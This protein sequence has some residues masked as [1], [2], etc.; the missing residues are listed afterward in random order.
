MNHKISRACSHL[1][2]HSSLLTLITTNIPVNHKIS[3]AVAKMFNS[4]LYLP[5]PRYDLL[6]HIPLILPFNANIIVRNKMLATCKSLEIKSNWKYHL[7]IPLFIA[8]LHWTQPIYLWIIRYQELQ[9]KCL[10][11]VYSY[12]IQDLTYLCTYHSLLPFNATIIVRNKVLDT[13]LW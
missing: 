7:H 3:R 5:Y 9:R 10:I 2:F 8:Y 4:S 1:I 12:L 11:V 6:M 13:C